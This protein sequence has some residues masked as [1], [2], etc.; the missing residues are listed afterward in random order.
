M[1]EQRRPKPE[2]LLANDSRREFLAKGVVA[3]AGLGLAGLMPQ[4][5]FAQQGALAANDRFFCLIRVY[6]G[7]DVTLGLDPWTQS[8]RPDPSDLFIEYPQ[9]DVL[10]VGDIR[11]APSAHALAPFAKDL[12]V[13]NGVLVSESDNGHGAALNYVSTGNGQGTAPDLPIEI[14]DVMGSGPYGVLTAGAIYRSTRKTQYSRASDIVASRLLPDPAESLRKVVRGGTPLE[15]AIGGVVGALKTTTA[16]KT[17]LAKVFAQTGK[18]DGEH[19]AAAGFLSGASNQA[20]IDLFIGNLDT[21]ADHVRNHLQAQGDYFK[22]VASIFAFFKSL[23]YGT[24]GQSLFDRTTFMV[25]SEFSRTPALNGSNGKDHNPFTNSVLLAGAGLQGGKTI[26]KSLL[27]EAKRS[28]TGASYHM[29]GP[30]NFK[31]GQ[32]AQTKADADFIFPENVVQTVAAAC[33]ADVS[34]LRSVPKGTQAIPGVVKP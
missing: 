10:Q 32:P 24:G 2:E 14:C 8:A 21:H 4:L 31:T 27:I 9:Q 33:G 7:W 12:V 1:S 17:E 20:M 30:F 13:I 15:R 34:K 25:V 19:V 22:R 29:A 18:L 26:N 3:G 23:P 6:G 28:K 16:L 5:S 11:L